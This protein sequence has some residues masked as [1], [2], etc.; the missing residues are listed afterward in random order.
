MYRNKTFIQPVRGV[1]F[2]AELGQAAVQ[3]GT[4]AAKTGVQYA[5]APSPAKQGSSKKASAAAAAAAAAAAVNRP[6]PVSA[7]I[8]PGVSNTVLIA[9]SAILLVG[10]VYAISKKRK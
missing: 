7:S 2:W 4:E 6:A 9:G 10:I 5:L 8:L 3:V 1:G